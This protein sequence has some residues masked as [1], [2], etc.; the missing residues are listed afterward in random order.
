MAYLWLKTLHIFL[1]ILAIGFSASF[2]LIIGR[3]RNAG[4]T[5][6][7]FALKTVKAMSDVANAAFILLL[8]TG[9]AMLWMSG[10]PFATRWVHLSLAVFVLAL[11]LGFAVAGPTLR[12]QIA[13]LEA[14][15]AE[16]AEFQTLSK[17][18]A[19]VGAVLG[20]MSLVVLYLM[21]HK[22]I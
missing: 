15:G 20:V 14:R 17:R 11:G 22:P 19:I 3:G 13:A 8:L 6:L 5:E 10:L 1:A 21:V 9:L 7:T 18:S 2:G 12:K 4:R 16:D